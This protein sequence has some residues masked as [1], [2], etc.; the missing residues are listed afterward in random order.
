VAVSAGE[1]RELTIIGLPAGA[2]LKGRVLDSR[3]GGR[4]GLDIE[5][6]L[7]VAKGYGNPPVRSARSDIEG[8]FV[9]PPLP[10]GSGRLS[11][12]D[13]GGDRGIQLFRGEDVVIPVGGTVDVVLRPPGD[14]VLIVTV[15]GLAPDAEG[16]IAVSA[17][18]DETVPGPS[19]SVSAVVRGGTA[20]IDGLAAGSYNVGLFAL[21]TKWR[22]S[23]SKVSVEAGATTSCV[24]EARRP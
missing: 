17:H 4:T 11:V 14:A 20:V 12:M 2:I 16:Q 6:H 19:Q 18:P 9:F 5:L 7:D 1:A 15:T 10:P 23:V 21:G 3:G 13:S 8:R 22:A 24:L